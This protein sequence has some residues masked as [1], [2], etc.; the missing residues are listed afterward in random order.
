M[1]LRHA[2]PIPGVG[3]APFIILRHFIPLVAFCLMKKLA[4][5]EPSLHPAAIDGVLSQ[6]NS[7]CSAPAP[8]VVV[9]QPEAVT[10]GDVLPGDTLQK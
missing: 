3:T 1:A 6:V 2:H 4:F 10:M 9:T 5:G 8:L 7:P